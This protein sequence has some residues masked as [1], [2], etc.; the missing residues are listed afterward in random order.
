ML[1]SKQG[2]AQYTSTNISESY[3]D[4]V[5]L[6]AYVIGD[7]VRDGNF[8]WKCTTPIDITNTI[9]PTKALTKWATVRASNR[10]AM[11]DTS[12]LTYTDNQH[13]T[14]GDPTEGIIVEFDNPRF[15]IIAFGYVITSQ[16]IIEFSSDDFVTIDET[17]TI[18][19]NS[20]V[21]PTNEANWYDYY[22]GTFQEAG[23]TYSFYQEIIP[24]SGKIRVTIL[25]SDIDNGLAQCGY[26]ITGNSIYAGDTQD[27][28]KIS[29]K[30]W[31]NREYDDFGTLKVLKRNVQQNF[32]LQTVVDNSY[33]V[34]LFKK[35]KPILSTPIL[36]VGDES[37]DSIFENLLMLGTIQ[38]FDGG[39]QNSPKNF[40]SFKLEE[41][42]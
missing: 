21:S 29:F 24:R 1:L 25:P 41:L 6:T 33:S 12:S 38:K 2:V 42:I 37:K 10:Y 13:N 32:Q 4:W 3:P 36:I 40:T 16:I 39:V 7:I 8:Y 20:W 15:D 14:S 11:L 23:E 22:Y 28:V 35:I 19:N 17:I 26:M 9:P 30:D 5:A 34:Q 27:N 31:S 18:N